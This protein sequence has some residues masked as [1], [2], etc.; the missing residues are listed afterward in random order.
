MLYREGGGRHCTET[1]AEV[2]DLGM[3]RERDCRLWLFLAQVGRWESGRIQ[4]TGI[5]ALPVA[6]WILWKTSFAC[7]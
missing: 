1:M 2:R 5:L 3:V 4:G 7:L 6:G